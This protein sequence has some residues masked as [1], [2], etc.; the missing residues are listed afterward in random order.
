MATMNLRP[1]DQLISEI[2]SIE[3]DDY[4]KVKLSISKAEIFAKHNMT[5]E[6]C[7]YFKEKMKAIEFYS[8]NSY[9]LEERSNKDIWENGKR[10]LIGYI[11]NMKLDYGL[12]NSNSSTKSPKN[13][14]NF[15][16]I[17][18]VHGHDREMLLD[19]EKLINNLDLNPKILQDEADKGRTV[20]EKFEDHSDVDFAI[21]LL[22]PEDK[23]YTDLEDPTKIVTRSRQNVIL[24]LGYFFS[25]LGRDHII[26]LHREDKSF[27]FPSDIFGLIYQPY[28][29]GWENDVVDELQSFG[30]DIDKN[31]I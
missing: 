3:Y 13:N 24:E 10:E 23:F 6:S 21:I 25:K 15:K 11:D 26:V 18:I 5:S 1:L 27:E 4:S 29:R 30:F 22:S 28:S 31:K 14:L 20:I 19:A 12:S 7:Q 2:E 17:F 8:Y 9:L 16:D